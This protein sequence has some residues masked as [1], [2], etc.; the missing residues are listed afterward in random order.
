MAKAGRRSRGDLA[1]VPAAL[2]RLESRGRELHAIALV[3]RYERLMERA[4]ALRAEI[5]A[6]G[7]AIRGSPGDRARNQ[8]GL[9][10]ALAR[11]L[12]HGAFYCFIHVTPRSPSGSKQRS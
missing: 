9:V 1:Q 2:L 5:Q 7:G 4:V 6:A 11:A 12:L 8:T 3:R 10:A